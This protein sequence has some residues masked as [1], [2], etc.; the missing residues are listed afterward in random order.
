MSICVKGLSAE[1]YQHIKVE[2]PRMFINATEAGED[3][4]DVYLNDYVIL[5]TSM[6]EV[7]IELGLHTYYLAATDFLKVEIC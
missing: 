4:V 3:V 5:K 7:K 2:C 1:V 6:E